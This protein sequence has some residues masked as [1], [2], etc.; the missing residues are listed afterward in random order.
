MDDFEG[1]GAETAAQAAAGEVKVL[2]AID[3]L[4]AEDEQVELVEV[5]EWGGSVWVRGLTAAQWNALQQSSLQGRG[6]DRQFNLDMFTAK[7]CARCMV[8]G[9]EKHAK[10]LFGPKDIE[11]LG[12][13]SSAALSRIYDAASRLSGINK[14]D[15][16]ELTKNSPKAQ[17]DDESFE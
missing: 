5:P 9:P 4:N 2:S 13:K 15:V 14:K 12:R 10:R 11:A 16:D 1:Q 17:G 8:A 6:D 3:I 7:L